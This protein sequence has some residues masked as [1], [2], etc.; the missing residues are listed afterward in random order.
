MK[1][2]ILELLR[3]CNYPDGEQD[4]DEMCA[5]EI[6]R[7]IKDYVEYFHVYACDMLPMIIDDKLDGYLDSQGDVHSLDEIF[8]DWFENIKNF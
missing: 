6:V 3:K 1:E 7:Y 8:D 4:D 5:E 2:K